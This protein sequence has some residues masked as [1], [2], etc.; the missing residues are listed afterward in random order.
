MKRTDAKVLLLVYIALHI[1]Y[2]IDIDIDNS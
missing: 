2:N 1:R